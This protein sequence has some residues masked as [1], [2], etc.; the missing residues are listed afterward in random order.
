MDISYL[1][2]AD[3]AEA[4]EPTG[5]GWITR[6]LRPGDRFGRGTLHAGHGGV[7]FFDGSILIGD[8]HA[9]AALGHAL[10]MR[11]DPPG[12]DDVE[13]AG[14]RGNGTDGADGADGTGPHRWRGVARAAL[15]LPPIIWIA[16]TSTAHFDWL[17]TGATDG[18]ARDSLLRAWH[19][20][21]EHTGAD[22]DGL[23]RD[24]LNM[25]HGV[26]GTAWRDDHPF[27]P[28]RP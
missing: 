19:E 12:F 13:A 15:T 26:I 28:P 17:G 10:V 22:P 3:A 7:E 1:P 5:S 18:E 16:E 4:A 25:R 8:L 21:A 9:L 24:E 2:P 20:H 27:P 23:R 11:F 6:F 14:L